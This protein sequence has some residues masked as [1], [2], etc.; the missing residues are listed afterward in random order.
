M[1]D[2]WK[3]TS[4]K[5]R[6][7]WGLILPF[8]VLAL[9]VA[10]YV[11][12]YMIARNVLREG[13]DDW[14]SAERSRGNIVQFSGKRMTGFP[15][16]FTLEVDEPTYSDPGQFEWKAEHLQLNMQPWNWQHVIA[17]SPGVNRLTDNRGVR[18][19]LDLDSQSAASL[20]WTKE[21]INRVG[22]QVKD[23]NG[24][25]DGNTVMLKE[26]SL[27]LSPRETSPDDLMIAM[28]WEGLQLDDAIPASF[29]GND[30]GP[31]R[32]IG[33]VRGFFPAYLS[34]GG[35]A[36][37]FYGALV[38]G[39]GGVEIAQLL[40][41]WG[42]LKLGAKANVQFTD[43]LA[44]GEIGVRI[45]DADDVRSA[46]KE[47]QTYTPA[48]E[49][50]LAAVEAGSADGQFLTLTVEDN[51]FYFLGQRLAEFPVF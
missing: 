8:S 14:I 36:D 33:E 15:F 24:V 6:S 28:Q 20:S 41:N 10:A 18:H 11:A 12:Y 34:S 21:R 32:L 29:L 13:I 23:A 38:Q 43:S 22:L 5:K 37:A 19:S 4:G 25:I 48:H 26:F 7:F 35:D 49:A 46:L 17:R 42:P 9:I 51:G 47:Q 45:D 2:N 44:N 39:D 31:T 30:I 3:G 40:L 27:N 1:T 50:I 16:R